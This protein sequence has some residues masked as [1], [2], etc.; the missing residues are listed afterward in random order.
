MRMDNIY[1]ANCD[2]DYCTQVRE[3]GKMNTMIVKLKAAALEVKGK[4]FFYDADGHINIEHENGEIVK[5]NK[6]VYVL[7]EIIA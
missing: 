7:D 3:Q 5:Y 4:S 2:C 6:A 1:R